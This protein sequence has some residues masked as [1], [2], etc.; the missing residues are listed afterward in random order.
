MMLG[1]RK[2]TMESEVTITI[3]VMDADGN[4][5]TFDVDGNTD[6]D[7][8]YLGWVRLVPE[9]GYIDLPLSYIEVHE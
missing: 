4:T 5:K 6:L 3:T 1:S 2:K 8:P 9:G 7:C